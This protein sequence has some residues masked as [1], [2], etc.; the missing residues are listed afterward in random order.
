MLPANSEHLEAEKP[1]AQ[2][3]QNTEIRCIISS[4]VQSN[5][6]SFCLDAKLL[7]THL[8]IAGIGA[9][10]K[11]HRKAPFGFQGRLR[12]DSNRLLTLLSCETNSIS[13]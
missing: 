7:L 4:S 3:Q 12:P 9:A 2:Q 5:D 13:K 8:E 6:C 1:C 11:S 10:L